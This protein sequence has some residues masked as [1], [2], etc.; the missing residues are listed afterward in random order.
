MEMVLV[1]SHQMETMGR[2]QWGNPVEV[3]QPF[4]LS[5]WDSASQHLLFLFTLHTVPQDDIYRKYAT[6]CILYA[7]ETQ[8]YLTFAS[9][10]SVSFSDWMNHNLQKLDFDKTEVMQIN[11]HQWLEKY[12]SCIL[13]NGNS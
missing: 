8:L 11:M 4:T 3:S 2:H 13:A 5:Q 6:P 1:L 9:G 12:K 7:D 10:T